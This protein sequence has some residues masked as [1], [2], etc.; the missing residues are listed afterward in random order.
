MSDAA[1]GAPAAPIP[2]LPTPIPGFTDLGTIHQCPVPATVAPS[3]PDGQIIQC[4]T[5]SAKWVKGIAG[6]SRLTI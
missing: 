3:T 4:N 6:W 1:L 5:C 2:S